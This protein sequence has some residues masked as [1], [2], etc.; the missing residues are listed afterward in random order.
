MGRAASP[1]PPAAAAA[2]GAGSPPAAAAAAPPPPPAAV[3]GDE[4]LAAAMAAAAPPPPIAPVPES[5]W[6]RAFTATSEALSRVHTYGGIAATM[7]SEA[8]RRLMEPKTL[9]Q[10]IQGGLQFSQLAYRSPTVDS[11]LADTVAGGR[12]KDELSQALKVRNAG[13]SLLRATYEM[14]ARYNR[15]SQIYPMEAR[16]AK[17]AMA[18]GGR[19]LPSIQYAF[20][21]AYYVFTYLLVHKFTE[22][23]KLDVMLAGGRE[24]VVGRALVR[25]ASRIEKPTMLG[26]TAE[27][28]RFSPRELIGI[29]AMVKK[30]LQDD[31][32]DKFLRDEALLSS[33]EFAALPSLAEFAA[34]L[35]VPEGGFPPR[36][37]D[38]QIKAAKLLYSAIQD[39][40]QTAAVVMEERPVA[41]RGLLE[42]M[43]VA[44]TAPRPA[45][46]AGAGNLFPPLAA[47]ATTSSAPSSPPAPAPPP[48]ATPGVGAVRGRNGD[49]T[50]IEQPAKRP[51]LDATQ[52]GP[53]AVPAAPA[54]ATGSNSNSNSPFDHELL[55]RNPLPEKLARNSLPEKPITSYFPKANRGG[56]RKS[57]KRRRGSRSS[58][59]RRR[60][61]H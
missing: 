7:A 13:V 39:R 33:A 1:P 24:M 14:L 48:A 60:R 42:R 2:A 37:R 52:R 32:L 6:R 11:I 17:N 30:L 61:H 12:T 35:D 26:G 3:A 27:I 47:A 56:A 53:G 59:H 21:K 23:K 25:A 41:V 28:L 44:A 19:I 8:Y 46:A 45:A 49:A 51:K 16:A 34:V 20:L 38:G 10:E 40:I 15:L 50:A 43:T 57:S 18:P 58:T 5:L 9:L 36:I 54:D 22:D 31:A 4:H 55:A 29:N